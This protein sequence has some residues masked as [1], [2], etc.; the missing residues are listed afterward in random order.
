MGIEE[1]AGETMQTL[2]Q[3]SYPKYNYDDRFTDIEIS[4]F[5][6][7]FTYFDRNGNGKMDIRDLPLAMRAM[8]AL[9]T[10]PEINLLIKKYDP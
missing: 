6:E 9:V 4:K 7:L 2:G 5:N 8:G 3:V 1:R 10:D